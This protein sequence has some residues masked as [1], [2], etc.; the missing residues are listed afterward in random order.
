M[1]TV[2]PFITYRTVL[3]NFVYQRA[4]YELDRCVPIKLTAAMQPRPSGFGGG[5]P[6]ETSHPDHDTKTSKG[7]WRMIGRLGTAQI[8]E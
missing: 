6:Q 5:Q 4:E 7:Q 3:S 8:A 1:G 2:W